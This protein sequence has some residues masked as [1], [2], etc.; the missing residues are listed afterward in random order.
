M[1][2]DSTKPGKN[3]RICDSPIGKLGL[4]VCYDVRFPGLYTTLVENG[5]DILLIPAAFTQ[6]T[7][8]AHWEVLLRA[9]AIEN[10]CYVLAAAQTG[11]HNEKR[12]SY[13]DAMIV[14]PWGTVVARGGSTGENLAVVAEI[15]LNRIKQIRK[16]MPKSSH[17]RPD[18]YS[19]S[20]SSTHTK[21]AVSNI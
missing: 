2:S 10:Q 9:R 17:R 5:A 7:G 13:G 15:D 12:V 18:L 4:S 19:S 3:L 6:T 8:M 21:V 11:R 14:D 1:E 20:T 16:C